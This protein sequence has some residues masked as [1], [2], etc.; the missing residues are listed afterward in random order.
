MTE[1]L[2]MGTALT[3]WALAVMDNI[4]QTGAITLGDKSQKVFEEVRDRARKLAFLPMGDAL[5]EQRMPL[6]FMASERHDNCEFMNLTHDPRYAFWGAMVMII[7]YIGY[8][9]DEDKTEWEELDEFHYEL[10]SLIGDSAGI[11]DVADDSPLP[12]ADKCR[13]WLLAQ[14][15]RLI[16]SQETSGKI[17]AIW[18][19]LNMYEYQK[20]NAGLGQIQDGVVN[21]FGKGIGVSPALPP[22][23]A[24]HIVPANV[25][26]FGSG[27]AVSPARP[28][29]P[30]TGI[31]SCAIGQLWRL[32]DGDRPH[33]QRYSDRSSAVAVRCRGRCDRA[34][35]LHLQPPRS[36]ADEPRQ[37]LR[38]G[39]RKAGRGPHHPGGHPHDPLGSSGHR[40]D[41]VGQGTGQG[42]GLH[43]Q[44]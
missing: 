41:A 43:E 12:E 33:R 36:H 32:P 35:A 14:A 34:G 38:R 1:D 44:G 9:F 5:L 23:P 39:D 31:E 8:R 25:G 28:P 19:D 4:V 27:V 18:E 17:G 30:V 21:I 6:F 40:Q 3:H 15:V 11:D 29:Y 24:P 37:A 16:E 2:L 20:T 7:G 10:L 22:T 42:H 26:I 13:R